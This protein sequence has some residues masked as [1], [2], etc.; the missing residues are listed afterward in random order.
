MRLLH[1]C[2]ASA[3]SVSRLQCVC[4]MRM[5][6]VVM[7][8]SP[9]DTHHRSAAS[10]QPQHLRSLTWQHPAAPVHRKS[11]REVVSH[12]AAAAAAAEPAASTANH[13][14]GSLRR[15]RSHQT[16]TAR[17]TRE[18]AC[19]AAGPRFSPR[20]E[21]FCVMICGQRAAK[22]SLLGAREVASIVRSGVFVEF[23]FRRRHDARDRNPRVNVNAVLRG[24]ALFTVCTLLSAHAPGTGS[25]TSHQSKACQ[26]QQRTEQ[27]STAQHSTRMRTTVAAAALQTFSQGQLWC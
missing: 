22:M 14:P 7:Q 3:Q 25:T 12:A 4:C 10:P 20:C 5:Q 17:S 13:T 19:P 27:H 15:P 1:A 23:F 2:N 8:P 9:A 6:G 21:A 26:A 11:S 18:G 24:F 16:G